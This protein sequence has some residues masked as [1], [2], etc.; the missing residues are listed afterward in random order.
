MPTL[1][2][3]SP[4]PLNTLADL[5]RPAASQTPSL[6]GTQVPLP[7]LI[8]DPWPALTY[9]CSNILL[10]MGFPV[11]EGPCKS[12][13]PGSLKGQQPISTTRPA[14]PWWCHHPA[15]PTAPAAQ[16]RPP[17]SPYSNLAASTETHMC[18]G[19]GEMGQ[20]L[21][22]L[23]RGL[24]QLRLLFYNTGLQRSC[25]D[26][27]EFPCNHQPPS[28]FPMACSSVNTASSTAHTSL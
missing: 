3:Q 22:V 17:A 13:G 28:T 6:R 5:P 26:W 9:T 10:W 11:D 7:N 23:R 21:K 15:A 14:E 19:W 24:L 2:Q 8:Q 27:E 1:A 25:R 16:H 4:L 18:W 20:G 12:P